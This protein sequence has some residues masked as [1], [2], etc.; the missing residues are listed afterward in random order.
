[1]SLSGIG[2]GDKI[3]IGNWKETK[4]GKKKGE[5]EGAGD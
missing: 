5:S 2:R 3:K 1:V 4:M